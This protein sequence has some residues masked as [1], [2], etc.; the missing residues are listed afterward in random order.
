MADGVAGPINPLISITPL[1]TPPAGRDV[2]NVPV[3]LAT[4][5]PGTLI[6]G[7]VVNRDPQNNP[8]L[9]TVLGD[10]LV[11][12]DVFIKTGSEVTFRVDTTQQGFARII[13]IDGQSPQDYALAN[14]GTQPLSTDTVSAMRLPTGAASV[15]AAIMEQRAIQPLLTGIL[16]SATPLSA[17]NIAGNPLLAANSPVPAGL[18]KL[19]LGS[20][21]QVKLV[22]VELPKA[23]AVEGH[24]PIPGMPRPQAGAIPSNPQQP[25]PQTQ[26]FVNARTAQVALGSTATPNGP[27]TLAAPTG[28]SPQAMVAAV[29]DEVTSRPLPPPLEQPGK[30]LPANVAR[31]I[32][33]AS[34]P[35]AQGIPAQVIG[36]EKDGATVFQTS[37]GTIKVPMPQPLPVGTAA[38]I[39]LSVVQ[40]SVSAPIPAALPQE[41]EA[42]TN[43]AQHWSAL[44][45]LFDAYPPQ[46]AAIGRP[47]MQALPEIGPKLTSGLLFF[48]AAVKG[49]DLKQWVGSKALAALEEKSPQLAA[50]LK[51]NMTQMQTLLVD[52]PLPHWNTAMVPMLYQGQLEHARL[53][54]RQDSP[55][56][57]GSQP[58][59]KTGKDQRFIVEV[60]LSHLGEMQFDGFVR[61]G[62]KA[63]Q[64]D[65]I[66]RSSL[67]LPPELQEQIRQTFDTAMQ[68]T[69]MTGYLG[70]Q[71]GSQHFVRPM[72]DAEPKNDGGAAQ[73]ILA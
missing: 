36:H 71:Q 11:K 51:Q 63:K 59:R 40:E 31:P 66:V 69:G 38:R 39:E 30:A 61:P 54:F 53:F 58:A 20:Q 35:A 55:E 56:D 32:S 23:S 8:V 24:Q 34:A 22:Q 62:E 16:V 52:S 50:R 46:D 17:A 64:F 65:L 70:F 19:Q 41:L 21:L 29:K 18:L 9:R 37:L 12:S 14:K 43:L 2:G 67:R 5:S 1:S 42:M 73:P 72:A 26:S 27:N 48:M 4:A 33:P 45:E 6:D 47:M 15:T 28:L 49:G 25:L 44:D 3:Q 10:I 68:T 13:S 57:G 7:F 60:D